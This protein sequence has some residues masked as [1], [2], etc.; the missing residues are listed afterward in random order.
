M[1]ERY[2]RWQARRRSEFTATAAAAT[3]CCSIGVGDGEAAGAHDNSLV[4]EAAGER[5]LAEGTDGT[6][7]GA[8]TEDRDA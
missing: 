8:L 5:T 3:A 6:A 7:A 4:E 2:R 1:P